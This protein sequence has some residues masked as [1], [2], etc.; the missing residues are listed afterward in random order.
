M[1]VF[2]RYVVETLLLSIVRFQGRMHPE[3]FFNLIELKMVNNLPLFTSIGLISGVYHKKNV[4]F[5][6][7]MHHKKFDLIGH[8]L[9]SHARCLMKRARWHRPLLQDEIGGC[10]GGCTL[11]N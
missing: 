7:S 2:S 11:E 10:R 6:G 8:Y 4:S 3:F 9:L 5:Q 1:Y